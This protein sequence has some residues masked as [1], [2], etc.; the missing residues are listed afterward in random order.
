[1][2][3]RTL[4]GIYFASVIIAV[5][6]GGILSI[7]LFEHF[8]GADLPFEIPVEILPSLR[9]IM[10]LKTVISFVNTAL[11]FLMLGIYIDLYRKIKT[12]FTAGLLLLILVLLMNVLTSNPLIY[13]RMGVPIVAPGIGF[14]IPDI[15]TTIALTVLFYISLE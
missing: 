5:I 6:L 2:K 7:I 15:F 14:I 8:V 9:F 10:S 4:I 12:T 13:L 3:K 1:M 11:I